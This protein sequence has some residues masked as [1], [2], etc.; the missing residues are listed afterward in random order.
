VL[1]AVAE[2]VEQ[3]GRFLQQQA[4][5]LHAPLPLVQR[6]FRAWLNGINHCNG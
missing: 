5:G 6:L 3:E 2:G 4:Q 1:V